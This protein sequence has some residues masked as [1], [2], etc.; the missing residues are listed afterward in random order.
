MGGKKAP[1]EPPFARLMR[2]KDGQGM[3]GESVLA[4]V[5][6]RFIDPTFVFVAESLALDVC[7]CGCPNKSGIIAV[8]TSMQ[9][10]KGALRKSIHDEYEGY[11]GLIDGAWVGP[12]AEDTCLEHPP[13]DDEGIC[14]CILETSYKRDLDAFLRGEPSS[15]KAFDFENQHGGYIVGWVEKCAPSGNS[16]RIDLDLGGVEECC[17]SD[18]AYRV[19]RQRLLM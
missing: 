12:R 11:F 8:C 4:G 19:T 16:M 18:R 1:R 3:D 9:S 7:D 13:N 2:M 6:A 5:V 10:A 17:T 15:E 14:D